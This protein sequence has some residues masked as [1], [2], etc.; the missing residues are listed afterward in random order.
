MNKEKSIVQ[1]YFRDLFQIT[2]TAAILFTTAFIMCV[3]FNGWSN[4][5]LIIPVLF[6]IV[7]LTNYKLLNLRRSAVYDLRNRQIA[8]KT[9]VIHDVGFDKKH[10]IYNN[11]GAIFGMA[12]LCLTDT[13]ENKFYFAVDNKWLSVF[14]LLTVNNNF[15]G[16]TVK[17]CFLKNSNLLLRCEPVINN[18]RNRKENVFLKDFKKIFKYY[19]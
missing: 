17:I 7:I 8:E 15:S 12:K 13:E 3:V 18:D 2:I 14:E 9:I 19:I 16:K 5:Y 6:I 1:I 11:G 10:S 4:L